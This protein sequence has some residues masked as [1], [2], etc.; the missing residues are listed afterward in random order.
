MRPMSE[1]PRDGS[2]ILLRHKDL[3]WRWVEASWR[4][5]GTDFPCWVST[6]YSYTDTDFSGWLPLPDALEE[7]NK[8]LLARAEAAEARAE[9]AEADLA[10]VT[11]AVNGASRLLARKETESAA[12]R[13]ECARLAYEKNQV[14]EGC[15]RLREVVRGLVEYIRS[16]AS[17][18]CEHIDCKGECDSCAVYEVLL[19][20]VA[21]LAAAEEVGR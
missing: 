2:T 14:V 21:A 16:W 17:T 11:E 4:K 19:G 20:R 15:S 10:V 18:A 6:G 13:E 12:L 1:A 8:A 3:P 5:V 7:E 9:K